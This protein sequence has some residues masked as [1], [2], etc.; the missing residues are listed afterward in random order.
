M[1]STANAKTNPK[2]NTSLHS[3]LLTLSQTK[4]GFSASEITGYSPEQVRRAAEAL[5]ADQQMVR[6][7]VS[8]RRVRYF[9]SADMAKKY[10]IGQVSTQLASRAGGPRFKAT[11]RS[12]EPAII[13]SRTKITVAPPLPRGV[14]RTNTFQQF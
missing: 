14:F 8:A 7:K 2:L 9:A 11:W 4:A 6:H 1:T 10:S 3:Q 12:D 13:T 5:V